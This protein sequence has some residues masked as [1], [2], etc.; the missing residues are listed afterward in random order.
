MPPLLTFSRRHTSSPYHGDTLRFPSLLN[1]GVGSA[2]LTGA[3]TQEDLTATLVFP[4]LSVRV[5]GC[6]TRAQVAGPPL[7]G[8][9]HG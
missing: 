1:T 2:Y 8:R 3:R 5:Q 7:T 6:Q 4:G 9:I